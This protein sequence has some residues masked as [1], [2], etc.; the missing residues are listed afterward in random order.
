LNK[1]GQAIGVRASN[2]LRNRSA[3]QFLAPIIISCV[4]ARNTYLKLL[5]ETARPSFAD[6]LDRIEPS[7]LAVSLFLGFRESPASLGYKDENYWVFSSYDHDAAP[8][9]EPERTAITSR[10]GRQ[11]V[12]DA[13]PGL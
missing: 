8:S 6:E 1:A 11:H 7:L 9:C 13:R 3:E 12:E 2:T 5:R 10:L 4:S